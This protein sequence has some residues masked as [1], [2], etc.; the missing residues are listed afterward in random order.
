MKEVL[1]MGQQVERL[2][3]IALGD[4]IRLLAFVSLVHLTPLVARRSAQP[5]TRPSLALSSSVP[6]SS[7]ASSSVAAASFVARLAHHWLAA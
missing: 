6:A 1:R 3:G 7:S 4:W 5:G 2:V